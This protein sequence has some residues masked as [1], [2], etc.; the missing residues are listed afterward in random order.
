LPFSFAT[1]AKTFFAAL[2]AVFIP[3]IIVG[4]IYFK[5]LS[6]LQSGVIASVYALILAVCV[7]RSFS[8]DNFVRAFFNSAKS[9]AMILFIIISA[10]AFS[11]VFMSSQAP[12]ILKS[13]AL[14]LN[15]SPLTF[16]FLSATIV[17]ILGTVLDGAAI[18]VLL[19]PALLTIAQTLGLGVVHFAMIMCIGAVL[20]SM[21]PPMAVSIFAAQTFSKLPIGSIVKGQAPFFIGFLAVY[22]LIVVFPFFSEFLLK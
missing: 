3:I 18:C 15:L 2:P 8:M 4:G 11:A 10:S 9:S 19:A 6:A 16:S 14:Y 1:F 20:G 17:I 7:Y 21:T 13:I 22:M 12:K 5:L